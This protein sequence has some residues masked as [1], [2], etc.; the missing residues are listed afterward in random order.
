MCLTDFSK[1]PLRW[2][3]FLGAGLRQPGCSGRNAA[4]IRLA[5]SVGMTVFSPGRETLSKGALSPTEIVV[6]NCR[7]I[8]ESCVFVFVPDDAGAGVYYELGF[9]DALGKIVLGFSPRGVIGLGKAIE[10]RWELLPANRRAADFDDFRAILLSLRSTCAQM[11][12]SD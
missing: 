9:A 11:R 1:V 7:A 8:E 10:G 4:L 2:D 3:L 6:Q 12:T 5:E